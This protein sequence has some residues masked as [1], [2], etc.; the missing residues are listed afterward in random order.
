MQPVVEYDKQGN[1]RFKVN[2]RWSDWTA[3]TSIAIID[4]YFM[5]TDYYSNKFKANRV[6]S[7]TSVFI[8]STVYEDVERKD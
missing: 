1:F 4:T 6:Y 8:G 2:E 7:L 3:Y 5:V